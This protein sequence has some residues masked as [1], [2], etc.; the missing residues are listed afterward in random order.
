MY[1][2]ENEDSESAQIFIGQFGRDLYLKQV[3]IQR[4]QRERQQAQKE[5]EERK[6]QES[7]ETDGPDRIVRNIVKKAQK[8]LGEIVDLENWWDAQNQRYEDII[9]TQKESFNKQIEEFEARRTKEI[10]ARYQKLFEET[11]KEI[12]D[13]ANK[14]IE[15]AK[16]K[17]LEIAKAKSGN[18]F[19][20]AVDEALNL[21]L[22]DKVNT[23]ILKFSKKGEKIS[24]EV[25]ASNYKEDEGNE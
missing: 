21:L 24:L 22:T 15:E 3:Q 23:I 25:S 7:P 18:E 11:V 19:Y 6:K 16:T 12:Q 14:W 4:E 17:L 8:K 5:A 9:E 1:V 20:D 2:D 10:E 13:D